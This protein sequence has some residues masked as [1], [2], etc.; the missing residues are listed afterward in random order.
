MKFNEKL[1]DL[2]KKQGLS[3]E[4]LGNKLNVTRQTIS[5]WELGQTTP[6]MDKLAELSKLFNIS[7]DELISESDEQVNTNPIKEEPINTKPISEEQTS[8]NTINQEKTTEDSNNREKTVKVIIIGALVIIVILIA[9]MMVSNHKK[10]EKEEQRKETLFS[11]IFDF[12]DTIMNQ[13]QNTIDDIESSQDS[14][15]NGIESSQD[16][17]TNGLDSM[18]ESMQEIEKNFNKTQVMAIIKMYTGTERGANVKT[19]LD[20]IIK[21][22]NVEDKK[23]TVKYNEIETQNI[24]EIKNLKSN[25]EDDYNYEVSVDY[26]E[27]NDISKVTIER[28]FTS[29]EIN[30]FNNQLEVYSGTKMGGQVS[31]LLDNIITKNKKEE[32]KIN[33]KYAEIETQDETQIRSIKQKMDSFNQYEVIFDYDADGFINK[34]TI[35]NI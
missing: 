20:N 12:I 13:A 15:T 11:M 1:I 6:E 25:I 18:N 33:V 35:Q 31:M 2:R 3:Q 32:R 16:F 28:V 23:I 7:I 19:V 14:M 10:V 5:K 8:S 9:G 21:N 22:N 17:I 34:V 29:F 30:K 24:E 27:S 26:N 4:E